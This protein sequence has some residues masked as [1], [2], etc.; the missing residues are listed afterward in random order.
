MLFE[1]RV[2]T[3]KWSSFFWRKN[4]SFN[5]IDMIANVYFVLLARYS[6]L[7]CV[8]GV[9]NL[10]RLFCLS[11]HDFWLQIIAGRKFGNCQV[12]CRDGCES[13]PSSHVSYLFCVWRKFLFL[14][15][16]YMNFWRLFAFQNGHLEVVK[17]LVENGASSDIDEALLI[18]SRVFLVFGCFSFS[19]IWVFFIFF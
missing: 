15:R 10:V 3:W 2:V 6:S 18:A 16:L 19:L 1:N 5:L 13:K 7:F 11:K 9:S 8:F 17:F 12:V 14:I 4:Q